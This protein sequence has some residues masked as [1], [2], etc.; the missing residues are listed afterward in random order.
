[1]KNRE[2]LL[3][4]QRDGRWERLMSTDLDAII[5]RTRERRATPS[6]DCP[7]LAVVEADI[8]A[9]VAELQEAQAEVQRLTTIDADL[10]ASA[11]IWCRLYEASRDRADVA[12]TEA[13]HLRSELPDNV[14]A[15]YAALDR[16]STLTEALGV[17]IRE[18]SVCARSAREGA[19]MSKTTTEACARCTAALE[20]LNTRV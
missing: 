17:V 10:R 15:L 13:A 11:E 19:T 9:L 7:D 12:E 4:G 20:A 5:N 2:A 6:H 14:R 16:V 18:C 8:Q 1:V 3:Q